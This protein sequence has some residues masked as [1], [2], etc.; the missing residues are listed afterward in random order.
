[1]K[2]HVSRFFDKEGLIQ[3][4]QYFKSKSNA[5][6]WAKNSLFYLVTL[7]IDRSIIVTNY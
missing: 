1:M 7:L 6:K 4:T 3:D 2:Y 5:I